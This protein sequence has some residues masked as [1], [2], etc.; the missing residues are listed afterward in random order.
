MFRC[1]HCHT[2]YGGI[3]G[4]IADRCPRCAAK[5][6]APTISISRGTGVAMLAAPQAP[7]LQRLH[8]SK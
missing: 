7:G 4:V 1:D 6:A 2:D 5:A 3:R 8:L